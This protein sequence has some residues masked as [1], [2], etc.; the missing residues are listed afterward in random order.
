VTAAGT[1]SNAGTLHFKSPDAGDWVLVI[2]SAEA[3]LRTPG[4]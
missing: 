4:T 2:D 3:K 1:F